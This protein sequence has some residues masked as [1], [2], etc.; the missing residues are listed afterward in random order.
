MKT[1]RLSTV[2]LRL[3]MN[4]LVNM[5]DPIVEQ[6]LPE[7]YSEGTVSV[8]NETWESDT[9]VPIDSVGVSLWEKG[10]SFVL[11]KADEWSDGLPLGK[12]DGQISISEFDVCHWR[13]GSMKNQSFLFMKACLIQHKFNSVIHEFLSDRQDV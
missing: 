11:F 2:S 8:Y 7:E 5:L 6:L 13:D 12:P 4:I 10:R 9:G 3:P 1:N